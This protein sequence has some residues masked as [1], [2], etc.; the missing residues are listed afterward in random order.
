[1][2]THFRC[3]WMKIRF[4][5]AML[6]WKTS[7][8]NYNETIIPWKPLI[9]MCPHSITGFNFLFLLSPT[10]RMTWRSASPLCRTSSSRRQASQKGPP[11]QVRSAAALTHIFHLDT[12]FS[13]RL[14]I[15]SDWCYIHDLRGGV[16]AEG[17]SGTGGV[18]VLEEKRIMD[19]P[20]FMLLAVFR[21]VSAVKSLYNPITPSP[22][23]QPPHLHFFT[24]THHP[25]LSSFE[26]IM[27]CCLH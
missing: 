6:N 7:L 11:R 20:P 4:S 21:L 3:L 17:G 27:S 5:G 1:M 16:T 24:H 13:L 10:G 18:C 8:S 23:L 19:F 26:L 22:T 14:E 25:A 12:C 2:T 9:F 15:R